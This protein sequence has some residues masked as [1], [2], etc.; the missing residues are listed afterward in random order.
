MSVESC[1]LASLTNHIENGAKATSIVSDVGEAVVGTGLGTNVGLPVG[2]DEGIDDGATVEG[3]GVGSTDGELVGGT[4]GA[5]V[6]SGVGVRVGP[7]VGNVASFSPSSSL[8]G[9]L[10]RIISLPTGACV[11]P[12]EDGA[13]GVVVGAEVG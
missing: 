9:C 10:S 5:V 4:T 8:G 2:L 3:A 13:E 6:G 7:G 12:G 11:G 1:T